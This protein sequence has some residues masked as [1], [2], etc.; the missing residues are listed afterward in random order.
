MP[1]GRLRFLLN[2]RGTGDLIVPG[3][4]RDEVLV[5]NQKRQPKKREQKTVR[6]LQR[7][8]PEVMTSGL[9]EKS[10]LGKG[11]F[12]DQAVVA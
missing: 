8:R 7:K 2:S 5:P 4:R 6:S 1:I 9:C 12:S 11:L 3:W 10:M